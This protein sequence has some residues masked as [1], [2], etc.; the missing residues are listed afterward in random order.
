MNKYELKRLI[1]DMYNNVRVLFNDYY[2][3][4]EDYTD[5]DIEKIK[6]LLRATKEDIENIESELN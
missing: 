3:G 5:E 4:Y 2:Y 6:V 1:F